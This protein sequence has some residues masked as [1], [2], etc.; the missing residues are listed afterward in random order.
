M[1]QNELRS[2]VSGW[3][4]MSVL[5]GLVGGVGLILTGIALLSVL[6]EAE[7]EIVE[8]FGASAIVLLSLALPAVY[9]A[10]RSWFGHL[11][12]SGFGS[13]SLGWVVATVGIVLTSLTMPPLS[14]TGFLAFLLGL[15]VAMLGA[16]VFGVAILRSDAATIPRLGAY[17]LIAALPVGVPFAIGFTTYVMGEGADPWAGSM[18][19]YGLAWVVFGRS[20]WTRR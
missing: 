10:E 13:M 5:S 14:E 7:F 15:L 4:K 6:N 17:C 8:P 11:A 1:A 3:L 18:I 20:L 2:A 19:L 12:K 16:L 9:I